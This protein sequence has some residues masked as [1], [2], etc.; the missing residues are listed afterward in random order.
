[1]SRLNQTYFILLLY[2]DDGFEIEA[3]SDDGSDDF[4]VIPLPACFNPDIPLS[5]DDP[6]YKAHLDADVEYHKVYDQIVSLCAYAFPDNFNIVNVI[7]NIFFV[8]FRV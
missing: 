1:M 2:L 5:T 3:I 4:C 8:E 7:G 6:E